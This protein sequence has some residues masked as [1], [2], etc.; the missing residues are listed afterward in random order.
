MSANECQCKRHA[1]Q[2]HTVACASA[3]SRGCMGRAL[4]QVFR[5]CPVVSRCGVPAA[6]AAAPV[7]TVACVALQQ[8]FRLCPVVSRC[9]VPAAAAA[10]PVHTVACASALSRVCMGRA[11]QQVFRL[12]PVV[13][14]CGVPAAAA[15]APV[16]FLCARL[17]PKS[18]HTRRSRCRLKKRRARR[19]AASRRV[20]V[21]C[22][23]MC[24]SV[25]ATNERRRC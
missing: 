4:L 6:V 13:S 15:A 20:S 10:A 17:Q 2:V 23:S 22:G 11:L 14:R 7:H 19:P 25:Y 3:L 21:P 5:L 18:K 1:M 12:R 9:G 24:V 8:V 16:V